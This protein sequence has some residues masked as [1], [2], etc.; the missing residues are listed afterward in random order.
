MIYKLEDGGRL[1]SGFTHEKNDCAVRTLA[2][3]TG[4]DYGVAHAMLKE[5]GRRDGK[6]TYGFATFIK[7]HIP[8]TECKTRQQ[9]KSTIG[10]F[11]KNKNKGTYIVGIRHHVFAVIDGII[12][13]SW[14][15]KLGC[16]VKTYWKLK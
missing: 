6:P 1:A 13:D 2:I 15:P 7:E 10:T 3:A 16:H 12:H 14:E 9:I 5:K 8:V 4:V 11:I